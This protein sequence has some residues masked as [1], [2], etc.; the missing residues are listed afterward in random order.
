MVQ[1]D[2]GKGLARY[3]TGCAAVLPVLWGGPRERGNVRGEGGGAVPRARGARESVMRNP[4]LRTAGSYLKVSQ[5]T[6]IYNRRLISLI[7]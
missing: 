2:Q 5:F 4:T 1:E 6:I 7:Y 3:A